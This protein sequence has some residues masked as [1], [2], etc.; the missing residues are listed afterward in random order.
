MGEHRIRDKVKESEYS[1]SNMYLCMKM[2][3]MRP[4]E[5]VLTRWEGIQRRMMRGE[6][7]YDIL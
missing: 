6:F 1:G 3:K 7:D 2:E 5:T 4:V